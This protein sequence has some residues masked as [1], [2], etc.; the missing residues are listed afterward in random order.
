MSSADLERR[1]TGI[2]EQAYKVVEGFMCDKKH[3]D[4]VDRV[5]EQIIEKNTAINKT[6]T[7][8]AGRKLM[9]NVKDI[10]D[11]LCSSIRHEILGNTPFRK[12]LID[13][14]VKILREK[15][16]T[17][18]ALKAVRER[19]ASYLFETPIAPRGSV[20]NTYLDVLTNTFKYDLV[21]TGLVT[22]KEL[23][24]RLS[25]YAN[26]PIVEYLIIL[27]SELEMEAA[28]TRPISRREKEETEEVTKAPTAPIVQTQSGNC[29][30]VK[31]Y[32]VL[33]NRENP[34]ISP[35]E[36]AKEI[37]RGLPPKGLVEL[38]QQYSLNLLKESDIQ[39]LRN[40][41]AVAS[42]PK[43]EEE[44]LHPGFP[45]ACGLE[46]YG[47][48]N[49]DIEDYA[50]YTT[51]RTLKCL[52]VF[53][54]SEVKEGRFPITKLELFDS[55]SPRYRIDEKLKL[56]HTAYVYLAGVDVHQ[57]GNALADLIIAKSNP[58]IK[59]YLR[60][61]AWGLVYD[62]YTVSHCIRSAI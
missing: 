50:I 26:N 6:I 30:L 24:D 1:A 58:E 56:P 25:A 5:F 22:Y 43:P 39:V 3:K 12:E 33:S 52:K 40:I 45:S 18:E 19:I 7:T 54:E 27:L 48:F 55:S 14:A 49:R 21:D 38:Y 31:N 44:V 35:M 2:V 17:E 47:V 9:N 34:G 29:F 61:L 13:T 15:N 62:F 11:N 10:K 51:S 46:L 20:K 36:L 37:L 23:I 60:A 59:D 4:I 42:L 57:F 41:P 28:P 8:T 16:S 32:L 53:A